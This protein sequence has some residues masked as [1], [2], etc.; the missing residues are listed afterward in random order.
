MLA[1]S[2]SDLAESPLDLEFQGLNFGAS[3]VDLIHN[4]N[5]HGS[6]RLGA[7]FISDSGNAVE[8]QTRIQHFDE[9]RLQFVTH[10]ELRQSD[11]P[12]ILLTWV[13]NNP[14]S[15]TLYHD[16]ETGTRCH[17]SFRGLFPK[18]LDIE[19]NREQST[20]FAERIDHIRQLRSHLASTMADITYLG[21]FRSEPRRNYQFPGSIVRSVGLSG[22]RAPELLADDVLRQRGDVL[23]A[24]SQWA[25]RYLGGWPLV[26]LRQGDAFSLALQ[27]PSNP[28]VEVNLVDVGTGIAQALPLVVQRQADVIHRSTGRIEIVEQPELHLHPGVHGDLADLYV[29]AVNRQVGLFIVETHSEIFCSVSGDTLQKIGLIPTKRSFTGLTMKAREKAG[30]TP[31]TFMQMVKWTCGR[32]VFSLKTLTRFVPFV[33]LSRRLIDEGALCK[34]C[35]GGGKRVAHPGSDC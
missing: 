10:F 24:V 34:G 11:Q 13:G 26:L 9:Y 15:D 30:Y 1:Q 23:V 18:V 2:W 7:I 17:V 19:T 6:I 22:A 3:F 4:R 29:E 14:L 28:S 32:T 16:Q 35:S 5:P 8:L 31:S 25:A 12:P 33:Q 21:P 20:G 27:N